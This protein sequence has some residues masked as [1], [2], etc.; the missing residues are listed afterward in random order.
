MLLQVGPIPTDDINQWTRIA[1]RILCEL[2]V[3]PGDLD[4]VITDDLLD[5]W[6]DLIDTWSTA[7]AECAPDQFC[8][9]NDIDNEQ[10]EYLLHGLDIGV[11]STVLREQLTDDE[12]ARHRS[13]TLTIV[14]AFIDGLS[15]EGRCQEHLVDQVRASFGADLDH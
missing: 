9:F 14:Q 8:W 4:G 1:R 15:A 2:K 3:H 13:I 10:A 6:S 12:V 7:A 5:G 11:H